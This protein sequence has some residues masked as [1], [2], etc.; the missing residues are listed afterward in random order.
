MGEN[1]HDPVIRTAYDNFYSHIFVFVGLSLLIIS[2]VFMIVR[3]EIPRLGLPN[4][5]GRIAIAMGILWLITCCAAL[6]WYLL[7]LF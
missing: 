3:R 5:K 4:I 1:I 7:E 2:G 6:I